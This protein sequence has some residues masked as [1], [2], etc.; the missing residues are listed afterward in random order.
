MESSEIVF[1][2]RKGKNNLRKRKQQIDEDKASDNEPEIAEN[3]SNILE[4]RKLKQRANGAKI[5]TLPD[6]EDNSKENDRER[7]ELNPVTKLSLQNFIQES[8]LE[9]AEKTKASEEEK[10]KKK[11]L[12]IN[13]DQ[14]YNLLEEEEEGEKE[15]IKSRNVSK[16]APTSSSMVAGIE[17]VDLGIESRLKNIEETE[18]A[19]RDLLLQKDKQDNTELRGIK[20]YH[21]KGNMNQPKVDYSTGATDLQVMDQFKKR[22][23]RH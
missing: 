23:S 2:A 15:K 17:E 20:T 9:Q 12:K 16:E 10:L 5:G 11:R 6:I 7:E 14:N 3:I 4:L 19:K 21:S 1:K 22:T 13:F 18:K 8:S